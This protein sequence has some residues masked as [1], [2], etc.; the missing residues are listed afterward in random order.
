MPAQTIIV[1]RCGPV[2][3]FTMAQRSLALS[4][5]RA[6]SVST[7]GAD[8]GVPCCSSSRI[9]PINPVY[10]PGARDSRLVWQKFVACLTNRAN[11]GFV[12]HPIGCD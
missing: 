4:D 8:P 3:V 12:Q 6:A 11:R 5:M 1:T 2:I 7:D 9:T 10:R